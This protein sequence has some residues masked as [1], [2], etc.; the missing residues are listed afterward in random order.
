MRG[1]PPG[2]R[3]PLWGSGAHG[4]LR[5]AATRDSATT[6]RHVLVATT[7]FP[8]V[9]WRWRSQP[10]GGGAAGA[11]LRLG[12]AAGSSSCVRAGA[13]RAGVAAQLAGGTPIS[14]WRRC[15][16]CAARVGVGPAAEAVAP[17]QRAG[18][19]VGASGW[20]LLG[21][22]EQDKVPRHTCSHTRAMTRREPRSAVLAGVTC[23]CVESRYASD[24]DASARSGAPPSSAEVSRHA[25]RSSL[26]LGR[27]RGRSG[28][29]GGAKSC[30][31][32]HGSARCCGVLAPMRSWR[33]RRWAPMYKTKFVLL[34][35]AAPLCA[36]GPPPPCVGALGG[37]ADAAARRE[38]HGHRPGDA[39]GAG[40]RRQGAGARLLG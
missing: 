34:A 18:G 15:W 39:W 5:L 8:P 12:G 9:G 40:A 37:A 4:P 11:P 14:R 31:A 38:R 6:W 20:V 17:P 13:G 29:R 25:S 36:G 27:R 2:G 23:P 1:R 32:A 35:H 19:R 10:N 3:R 16:G 24:D 28:R 30:Y 22:T 26:T 7:C 21:M 33:W